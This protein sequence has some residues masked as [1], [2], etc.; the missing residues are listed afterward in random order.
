MR[1]S[2]IILIYGI[3]MILKMQLV[4]YVANNAVDNWIIGPKL[5]G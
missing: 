4:K 2:L 5:N 3:G 1:I